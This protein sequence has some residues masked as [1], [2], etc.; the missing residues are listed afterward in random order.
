MKPQQEL[1]NSDSFSKAVDGVLLR[2]MRWSLPVLAGSLTG[3]LGW[4]SIEAVE[5]RAFRQSEGFTKTEAAVAFKSID[6]RISELPSIE[7]KKRV[8][9]LE[10]RAEEVRDQQ[11]QILVQLQRLEVLI[12]G[13]KGN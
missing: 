7:W 12:A 11:T 9:V 10:K 4:V 5:N 13:L 2:F 1:E 3:V 6:A 8:E